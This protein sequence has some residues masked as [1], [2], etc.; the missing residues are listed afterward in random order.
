M[1]MIKSTS[2]NLVN[3]LVRFNQLLWYFCSF[4]HIQYRH[5]PSHLPP[6]KKKK[7]N[8]RF[9]KH[10][11][12]SFHL[13]CCKN[14]NL[15]W[16]SPYPV[17]TTIIWPTT[18]RIPHFLIFKRMQIK[19]IVD[20]IR[21][22]SFVLTNWN[23]EPDKERIYRWGEFFHKL[24]NTKWKI[25]IVGRMYFSKKKLK[26]TCQIGTKNATTKKFIFEPSFSQ[27]GQQQ[28]KN[29]H[30]RT[31]KGTEVYISI[32]ISLSMKTFLKTG[33]YIYI[34]I[35]IMDEYCLQFSWFTFSWKLK[36]E[37]FSQL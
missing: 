9:R 14:E 37:E 8:Q 16:F 3:V 22:F 29:A 35:K 13:R 19:W 12:F 32:H 24:D 6:P 26:T 36:N 17:N 27:V 2:M 20:N 4:P 31:C 18:D 10:F 25:C 11:F 21:A 23:K 15:W 34:Y 5:P 33:V 30:G 7:K 28:V 1:V